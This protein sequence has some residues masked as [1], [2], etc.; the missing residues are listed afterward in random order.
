MMTEAKLQALE[1]LD[2]ARTPGRWRRRSFGGRY[3]EIEW[4]IH[5]DEG[6]LIR[7]VLLK[8]DNATFIAAC[9]TAVPELIASLREA[10]GLLKEVEVYVAFSVGQ[11]AASRNGLLKKIRNALEGME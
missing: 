10:R 5:C 6:E 9:S 4:V 7:Y 3:E 8:R 1:A 2:K 11:G